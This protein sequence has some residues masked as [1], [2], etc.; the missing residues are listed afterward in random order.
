M[1]IGSTLAYRNVATG[2]TLTDLMKHLVG[3]SSSSPALLSLLRE[4][5]RKA[6]T[7]DHDRRKR[8]KKL[9]RMKCRIYVLQGT[10]GGNTFQIN[11]KLIEM[12]VIF[13]TTNTPPRSPRSSSSSS[14]TSA[15]DGMGWD[16]MG[17]SFSKRYGPH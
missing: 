7:G 16:G 13:I 4:A 6:P 14:A 17:G 10:V 8:W 5:T 1:L 15:Q 9:F 3:A 11:L 12:Q 2:G